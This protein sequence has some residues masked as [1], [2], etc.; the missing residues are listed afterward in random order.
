MK[1]IEFLKWMVDNNISAESMGF[2]PIDEEFDYEKFFGHKPLWNIPAGEYLWLYT[3]C[4]DSCD[5]DKLK[6]IYL[7]P[8]E[9]TEYTI[10]DTKEPDHRN[11]G[12]TAILLFRL[13]E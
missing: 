2:V 3:D 13:E 7:K 12:R 9:K 11:G 10:I 4:I 6:E 5:V 8:G 1:A